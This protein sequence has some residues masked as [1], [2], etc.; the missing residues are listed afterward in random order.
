VLGDLPLAGFFGNGEIGPVGSATHLHGYTSAFA[1]IRPA[2]P[3]PGP[4][5]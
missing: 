1:L 5:T 2:T 4:V 3:A